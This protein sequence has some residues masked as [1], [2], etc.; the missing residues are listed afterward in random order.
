MTG[1]R[2]AREIFC[3]KAQH[4]IFPSLFERKNVVISAPV[5][6]PFYSKLV[7]GRIERPGK[8]RSTGNARLMLFEHKISK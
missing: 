3:L 1:M 5:K 7:K 8:T 2:W 4:I 6:V